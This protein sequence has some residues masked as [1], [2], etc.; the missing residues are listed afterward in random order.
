MAE[1]IAGFEKIEVD[2]DGF[3]VNSSDWTTDVANAIAKSIDIELT[4]RHW[5]VINYARKEY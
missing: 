4:D 3:L 2:D 5:V 1:K